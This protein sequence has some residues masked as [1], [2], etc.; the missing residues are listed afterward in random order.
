MFASLRTR[1]IVVYSLIIILTVAVV[2]FLILDSY[3]K[4]R[5][6]ERKITYFTYGSMISNAVLADMSDILYI[7][8][9]LEQYTR[10]TS[11]RFLLIG[12]NTEVISDSKHRYDGRM[13]TNQQIRDALQGRESWAIYNTSGRIMQLAVPVMSGTKE[14]LSIHGA[15][16]IS[17]NIEDLYSSYRVLRLKVILISA[18]A[19]ISG[20]LVS[21]FAGY[22]LSSPLNKLIRFSRRLSRG[23]LGETIRI[24]RK[25]EIGQLAETINFLSTDLH[26]LET[27][28]RRFIGDVSHELKTPLASIKALVES[29]LLRDECPSDHREFLGDVIGEVDRLSSIITRLLT[30][31]RLEEE[32]L[33]SK[34]QE[35]LKIVEETVRV[36]K[37]L[38]QSHR[39]VIENRI[40]EDMIIEC[41][42][43]LV[44]E[45]LVNLIDNSIKYRDKN[46]DISLI[47]LSASV[48]NDKLLFRIQDNGIGIPEDDLPNIFEGFY[49]SE[50][51]RSKEV[52]GYG[53]GLAI[54][55]RI[56]ELH[57][58][59]I[60][61]ESTRGS[62]TAITITIPL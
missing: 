1:L 24:K 7:S 36:M 53:I 34:P 50:R 33:R 30:F 27:N 31:T 43:D 23:H 28:R 59:D 3:F 32:M 60:N 62:G 37:P 45:M 20:V 44:Q 26:R 29:L 6:E 2:D 58:W 16:L 14:N 18:L 51:S 22:R 55:K 17:A 19:G 52:E 40:T 38:A 35:F 46:K 5:L 9:T 47:T 13:I 61:A 11:A 56:I 25:D 15:V 39:V 54:V 41:D 48:A 4:S 12:S 49:R 57:R 10:S 21:M 8:N 42:K